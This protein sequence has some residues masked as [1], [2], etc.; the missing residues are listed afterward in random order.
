MTIPKDDSQFKA[1]KNR[2]EVARTEREAAA[3]KRKKQQ[4]EKDEAKKRRQEEIAAK[5]ASKGGKGR[6]SS[7]KPVANTYGKLDSKTMKKM[8][9]KE[10]KTQLKARGASVIGNKKELLARLMALVLD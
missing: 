5:K 1:I 9:P 8:K 6:K 4:K 3:A 7:S 10:L 2:L